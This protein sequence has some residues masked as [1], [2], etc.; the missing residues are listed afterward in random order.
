[1]RLAIRLGRP[2]KEKLHCSFCGKHGEQCSK[3]VAGPGVYICNECI[4]FAVRELA[5]PR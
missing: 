1:M 3:L 2:D 4:V 5:K